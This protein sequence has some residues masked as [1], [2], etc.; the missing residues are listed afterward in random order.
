MIAQSICPIC[1]ARLTID[2]E[3]CQSCGTYTHRLP[4]VCSAKEA[5]LFLELN[6]KWRPAGR[7]EDVQNPHNYGICWS[8]EIG[9]FI[10]VYNVGSQESIQDACRYENG[11]KSRSIYTPFH[12]DAISKTHIKYIGRL[13]AIYKKYSCNSEIADWLSSAPLG[14]V[15]KVAEQMKLLSST[16]LPNFM[17]IAIFA[18]LTI[19]TLGF[20]YKTLGINSNREDA[21]TTAKSLECAIAFRFGRM[22]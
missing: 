11:D 13:P 3:R 16:A 9:R 17:E 15:R 12:S 19:V 22:P 7:S 6:S 18:I 20:A 21:L 8:P 10:S 4:L 1:K 2:K 14:E 5:A